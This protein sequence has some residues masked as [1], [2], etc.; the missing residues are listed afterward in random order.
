MSQNEP[1]YIG[2]VVKK[3][4][5]TKGLSQ[6]ELADYCSLSLKSIQLIEANKQEPKISTLYALATALEFEFLDFMREIDHYFKNH[7]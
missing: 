2:P 1:I 5:I 3:W 7:G 6:Q 4:R